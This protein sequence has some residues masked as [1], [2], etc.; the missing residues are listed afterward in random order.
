[1]LIQKG[2][3]SY[4]EEITAE[5]FNNLPKPENQ[6][7]AADKRLLEEFNQLP[8]D[9]QKYFLKAFKAINDTKGGGDNGND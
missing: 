6:L 3:E 4:G 5:P 2:V 9:A 7:S 8:P 1:M